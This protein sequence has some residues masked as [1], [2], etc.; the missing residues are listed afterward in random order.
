GQRAD[1][2]TMLVHTTQYSTVHLNFVAE[3]DRFRTVVL[4][5]IRRDDNSLREYLS[6][7]WRQES[8]AVPAE[9]LG[10]IPTTFEHLRQHL[11]EIV[12]RTEIKVENSRSTDRIDYE[13]GEPRT[14]IVIGGNVLS[15]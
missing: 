6:A 9:S 2:S 3:V 8:T 4:E 11:E 14:Y 7:V 15:R 12:N 1:H 13:S 5:R 10:E